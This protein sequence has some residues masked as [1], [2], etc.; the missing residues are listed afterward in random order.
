MKRFKWNIARIAC[1]IVF[2]TSAGFMMLLVDGCG[3][4]STEVQ[5]AFPRWYD[6]MRIMRIRQG[7]DSAFVREG[8][9]ESSIKVVEECEGV[10]IVSYDALDQDQVLFSHVLRVRYNSND[11]NEMKEFEILK[12]LE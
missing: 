11:R 12:I 7:V 1:R 10:W 6:N 5:R 3:S 4:S 9:D 2:F 8:I